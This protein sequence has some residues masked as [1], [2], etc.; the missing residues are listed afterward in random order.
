[1]RALAV[2][3]AERS[4]LM[5]DIPGMVE[6]GV[7]DYALSFWYGLFVPTGTPREIVQTLYNAAAAAAR[8]PKV[9]ETLAREGTEV[10]TS[11]SPDDFAGFLVQD[12]KLWVRLAKESGARAD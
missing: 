9:R 8:D 4:P 2:T 3:S 7:P 1:L 10:A 5:P 6:A 12:E 11:R